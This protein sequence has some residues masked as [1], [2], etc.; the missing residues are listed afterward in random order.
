M[1]AAEAMVEDLTGGPERR[2]AR[3]SRALADRVLVP[4]PQR[5]KSAEA[6]IQTAREVSELYE[7]DVKVVKYFEHITVTYYF[8]A[9]GGLR[10]L[11]DV[12][13]Y[14][15]ELSFFANSMGYEI[16]LSIDH[17]TPRR[18][19]RRTA[20]ISVMIM[21]LYHR[22]LSVTSSKNLE[23]NEILSLLYY[24]LV[25]LAFFI[26]RV[27]TRRNDFSFATCKIYPQN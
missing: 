11:R 15:D 10:Y 6:F 21:R 16:V 1:A 22:N 18:I 17:Y 12:I 27:G 24:S 13:R 2:E 20:D 7:L 9:G 4:L 5:K 3:L 26:C 25:F 14:A 19:P 8:N 23:Y